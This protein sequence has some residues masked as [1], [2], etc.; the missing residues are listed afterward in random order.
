MPLVTSDS[1]AQRPAPA[2]LRQLDAPAAGG[3]RRYHPKLD[4]GETIAYRLVGHAQ[5]EALVERPVADAG[6][7]RHDPGAGPEREQLRQQ[8]RV[9]LRQQVEGD[10]G[11]G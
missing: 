9:Q 5:L 4:A 6:V 8:L 7:V 1:C 3:V 2:V 11:C 10:H